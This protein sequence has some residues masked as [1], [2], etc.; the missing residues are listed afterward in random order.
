MET[1]LEPYFLTAA[2][3][4]SFVSQSFNQ[5]IEVDEYEI[6]S[7]FQSYDKNSINSTVE[8]KSF[9]LSLGLV[10]QDVLF[11]HPEDLLNEPMPII[12]LTSEMKWMVCV[13]VGNGLKLINLHGELFE[14]NFSARQLEEISAFKL[15]PLQKVVAS[16]R[17][18]NILKQAISGNKIFYSKYFISSFFMA[19][20]AL[21]IPVFNNLYYDKLVPSAS[22]SSLVGLAILAAVFIIFEFIL[23]SSK[24]I[25]QS[26]VS[27]KSDVDIDISFLEAI[28]YNKKKTGRSMSSAFVLWNEFQKVKPVLLNNLFQ[29]M[30]DIPLFIIFVFIIYVNLGAVVMLPVLTLILSILAAVLNHYYT[31]GLVE[32]QKERQKNRNAF[33]TEVLYSIKMI[34]TLNNKNLLLD[35]VNSSN[36]QSYLN[37]KIRKINMLYQALMASF[38]TITQIG[39]MVIA[40]FMVTKGEITTGA[41]ISAVIVAGRLSGIISNGASAVL[42]VLQAEKTAKDLMTYFDEEQEEK[43]LAL[44]TLAYCQGNISIMGVSYQYDPQSPPVLTNINAEIPAGQRIVIIGDCG[45]GKSTL[46]NLL[47]RYILPGEGTILYDGYNLNHFAQNFFSRHISMLS[48]SDVLFTGS[49]ESNFALKPQQ[50]K[51]KVFQALN[52]TN[53]NFVLQ[54]PMG[55]RYPVHFMAKNLSS[56]QQQ[57]LLLARSLS[58]DA[59]IFLWDEPTSHI[60]EQ[61]EKR[62]FDNLDNFLQNKTLIMVT[63][64]R[65]LIRYFHRVWVMK[66]GRIIRDC[67]PDKLLA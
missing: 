19:V 66:N 58:S 9:F 57:Q 17:V 26:I 46:L 14:V 64:R 61:A 18:G 40:F 59:S 47:T 24:D 25:Y 12:L 31:N 7:R 67:S 44:Q 43:D 65:Y 13:G 51:K 15:E 38:S 32:K 10:L 29:R 34:H 52:V 20:F 1:N 36:E 5:R 60:D 48:A 4:L 30:A 22:A 53:C 2:S 11:S 6:N 35:W 28:I 23:R 21:T 49:I 3:A 54:H 50:D 16:I 39:I 8:M 41:I 62:I 55:L 45:A 42:S 33:M 37:L 27:R 56:G 63:H